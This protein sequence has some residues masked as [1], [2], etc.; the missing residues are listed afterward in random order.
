MES[1]QTGS[2]STKSF[3]RLD[4]SNAN[5]NTTSYGS[6][7]VPNSTS[8]TDSFYPDQTILSPGS[9]E[10]ASKSDVFASR[11][12]SEDDQADDFSTGRAT[13]AYVAPSS[14]DELPIEVKSLTERWVSPLHS[15]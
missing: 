15:S 7:E 1:T 11:D 3:T 10:R 2:H 12:E 8:F 13:P 6:P 4:N 9:E 5:A 14:I